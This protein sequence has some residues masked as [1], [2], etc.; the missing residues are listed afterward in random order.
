[1][2]IARVLE[3]NLN[4]IT[5]NVPWPPDYGGMIDTYHRLRCLSEAGIK[6][7]L[8][9][10]TYGRPVSQELETM[11]ASVKYY[12]RKSTLFSHLSPLPYTVITRRSSELEENL[13]T[14]N[15]PLLFDGLHT[16]FLLNDGK[17]SSRRMFVRMHN[18]EHNYYLSRARH[19]KNIFRSI[20]FRREAF[21]LWRFENILG[22]AEK[23]FPI[24][25]ADHKYLSQKF[26]NSCLIP[27]FHPFSSLSIK[28]GK[29]E[30]LLYHGDL[31]VNENEAIAMM[32]TR[33]V[34]SRTQYHCIIA[35]KRPSTLLRKAVSRFGNIRLIADPGNIEMEALI[36][37][38]Q[39]NL[40][41]AAE[42][43][44]FKI[45][46][47]FTLFAGRHCITNSI[48]LAGS[49]D[50][51]DI[52]D[53]LRKCVNTADSPK[54]MLSIINKLTEIPL[55]EETIKEREKLLNGVFNNSRNAA[56]LISSIFLPANSQT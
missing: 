16:C 28:D 27:P 24:S 51:R 56:C 6:I 54:E 13:L 25:E 42:A 33:D 37:N 50:N 15:Y 20:Y 53:Q 30:Y 41:P 49:G 40:I 43:E 9:C 2:I 39:I 36:R 7:H 14:N 48:M 26:G 3:S 29:G 55:R 19:E 23:L 31:S 8:H 34:F 12:H 21:R 22:R 10:F 46:L 11:C 38:A 1:M 32:L 52:K 17:F 45:K 5:L 44:G 4:I 47:L 35:G 18:I